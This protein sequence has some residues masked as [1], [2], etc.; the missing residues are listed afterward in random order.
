MA[1]LL[2][3]GLA[4]IAYARWT[5]PLEEAQAAVREGNLERALE[6]YAA[7]ESRFAKV[8]PART[9]FQRDYHTAVENHVWALYSLNRYDQ[10][11]EKAA[12]SPST[13]KTHFWAANALFQKARLEEQPEARTS[14]LTRADE[15]YRK[16]LQL[17][18]ED[19]DIKYNYELTRR[20]LTELKKDPKNQQP[21]M[22]ILRPQPKSEQRPARRVG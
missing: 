16:A 14:W 2:V 6:R 21:L 5:K 12:A 4:L 10:T 1:V 11:I 22:Q 17:A 9:L 7:A 15:E 19:W 20:I 8:A 3:V 13:P 18:P